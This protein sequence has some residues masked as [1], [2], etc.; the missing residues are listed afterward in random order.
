MENKNTG[1]KVALCIFIIFTLILAGYLFYEKS[2]TKPNTSN[3]TALSQE[4]QNIKNDETN[5]INIKTETDD[6]ISTSVCYLGQING[7]A[8]LQKGEVY[9]NLGMPED[10]DYFPKKYNDKDK[11]RRYYYDLIDNIENKYQ[12]YKFDN[13]KYY[14]ENSFENGNFK[15]IKLDV[16]D[17]KMIHEYIPG[18]EIY[19]S[20]CYGLLLLHNDGTVSAITVNSIING[21][22]EPTKISGLSGIQNIVTEEYPEEPE[23]GEST[24]IQTLVVNSKGEKIRLLDYINEDNYDKY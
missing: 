21:K 23:E 17:V 10:V 12:E 18:P 2:N 3:N 22:T 8:I 7:V 15:G 9:V 13:F 19:G 6:A 16:S 4:S 5:E 11:N 14:N 20:Y 1:L 24:A